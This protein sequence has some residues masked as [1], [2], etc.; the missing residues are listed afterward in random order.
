MFLAYRISARCQSSS[1][2]THPYD[3]VAVVAGV[4]DVADVL[5]LLLSSLLFV[6]VCCC[7]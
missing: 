7:L 4:A 2:M 1:Q 5:L 6:A 3:A